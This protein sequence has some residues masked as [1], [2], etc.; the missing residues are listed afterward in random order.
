MNNKKWG[1]CV[2]YTM[3]ILSYSYKP[4][5]KNKYVTFIKNIPQIL[6]CQVCT[7]HF[8]TMLFH[9]PPEKSCNNREQMVKFIN[10]LHNNVNKRIKKPVINLKQAKKIYYKQNGELNIYHYRLIEFLR[11]VKKYCSHGVSIMIL[12]R[13]KNLAINLCHLYPHNECQQELIKL[14]KNRTINQKTINGF[15]QAMINVIKKYMKVKNKLGKKQIMRN[16]LIKN[17]IQNRP[18]NKLE[19]N[20]K[21]TLNRVGNGETEVICNQ[22]NSTP[23]VKK[24]Y[25]LKENKNYNIDIDFKNVNK[26]SMILWVKNM[27]TN[28]VKIYPVNN[29]EYHYNYMSEKPQYVY[30]GLSFREPR[31][32]EKF[33]LNKMEMM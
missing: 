10:R 1:R 32:G 18:L 15:L 29:G 7:N 31:N 17:A 13:A 4:N 28:N 6:P 19:K 2:W 27:T 14:A 11:L 9:N 24:L 5:K 16:K 22:K 26:N 25:H 8:K 30:L 23:G 21:V 12:T 20:Q 33:I 3:H